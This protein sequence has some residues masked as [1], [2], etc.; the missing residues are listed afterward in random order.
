M[1]RKSLVTE[2][3]NAEQSGQPLRWLDWVDYG[4][5]VILNGK[6]VPWG[7]PYGIHLTK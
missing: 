2:I 6:E 1:N 3:Q 7:D 4:Q 5:K